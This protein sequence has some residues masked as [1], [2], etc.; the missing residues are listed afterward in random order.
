MTPHFVTELENRALFERAYEAVQ[1]MVHL[2]PN[3][4]SE[5]RDTRCHELARAGAYVAAA[6]LQRSNPFARV[7]V[8]DGTYM[9]S[10]EHSWVG[11]RIGLEDVLL[12]PYAIGRHPAVQLV[13]TWMGLH[14]EFRPDPI[15]FSRDDIRVA[16]VDRVIELWL[17]DSKG[18]AP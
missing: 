16:H 12:D 3:K 2:A 14:R 8:V 15:G 13:T 10:F 7:V 18:G 6:V 4:D 17:K 11:L 1:R 5:D 9:Q